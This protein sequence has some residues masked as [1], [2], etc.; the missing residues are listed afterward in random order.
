MS[1]YDAWLT[2]EPITP[3][4]CPMCM[5]EVLEYEYDPDEEIEIASCECGWS[6]SDNM[7]LRKWEVAEEHAIDRADMMLD[8]RREGLL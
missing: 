3:R 8:M 7:L 2:T 5:R 1:D 6:G 4:F